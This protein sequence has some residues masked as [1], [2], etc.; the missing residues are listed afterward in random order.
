MKY[1]S[2]YLILFIFPFV[3]FAQEPVKKCLSGDDFASWNEIKNTAISPDGKIVAFEQNP[4]KG[5]GSLI[6]HFLDSERYDT[7]PR[8]TKPKFGPEN[9]FLVFTIAQPEKTIRKAKL[10]KVK[11]EDMPGDSLGVLIFKN[12]S[13]QK[14]PDLKSVTL[15]EKNSHWF[16]F[17]QKPSAPTDSASVKTDKKPEKQPGD[18]LVLF[19]ASNSDTLLFRQVTEVFTGKEG[20]N[21]IFVSQN[22]DSLST[23]SSVFLFDTATEQAKLIFENEG[24]AKKAVTDNGGQKFAFLFSTDTIEEKI[25]SLYYGNQ[26][27]LPSEIAGTLTEGM[28]IGWSPGENGRIYFSDDAQKL[29]FGT[30][31]SPEPEPKDTLPDDE[32]PKL[33]VWNW[34]DNLLQTQQKVELK[35]E[36]KRTYLAVLH[37]D[38]QKFIQLGFPDIKNISTIQKGNAALAL[39]IDDTP[40]QRSDSWE[41][42]GK[43]DFYLVDL[44]TGIKRQVVK[45]KSIVSLSPAGKYVI[46]YAPSDSGYY[47][48]STEISSTDLKPL[49][50]KIPVTFYDERDDTP[51]DPRPYGIAGW[52]ADDRSVFIYDRYDI[53][54][55][56]P[57]DDRVPVC[58]TKAF[59]RRNQTRLRIIKLDPE[60]EFLSMEKPVL[61]EAFDERT[62][63]AGFFKTMLN[64]VKDPE[65]LIADKSLFSKPVKAKNADQV[66]WTKEDIQTFPDLWVSN[67]DF[68]RPKRVSFANPQQKDFIWPTAELAEWNSFS[69]EK[70]KG[71]LIKPENLNPAKKYPMI[72]YYYER[73]SESLYRYYPPSPSRSTVEKSFYASNGYLVFIP[74][75]TYRVGYPGESAYNAVV[76]GANYLIGKYPF[77]DEKRIGL[78]GQSWGGYQTAYLITRTDMFAA[79]MAGAPV[80]NMTSAYGGIRWQAGVSRMFQYEHFQSRIGGTLWEKPLFYI[81]NSP[82]FY[83]PKIK[84][85]LLMMHNDDDGAVPWTQGIELFVALRRLDKPAWL[86]DY[87]G[88]PHNLNAESWANRIDLSK[89]MFQ[90]FNHYLKGQ[91]MPEWMQ[92]GIPAVKKGKTLGY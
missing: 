59:G 82:L 19:N 26:L 35:D 40:Y 14:F 71:V 81:E 84:T 91:P 43:K 65:L 44:N 47:V 50:K 16:A 46:W 17:L 62:M 11:K 6:V 27:A 33:D 75:I 78:Q 67:T 39:G 15:P 72:I 69:G 45:G 32:K 22:K 12:N 58:I 60:E 88:E 76:S 63:S 13:A 4:Q 52:S 89:R 55:I 51:S 9:D 77:V 3:N 42:D 34:K 79:A 61:L 2:L 37:L 53:W 54:K 25:Y 1:R 28:P 36:Q 30:A 5:D 21:F 74:D 10:D 18:N 24:F 38:G 56:D 73:N 57:T 31:P 41:G 20:A 23:R 68:R 87:N 49:T 8:G 83:A 64:S 86:L 92:K 85:P 66:F 80:S 29:Y 7:I 48:R 70:L 90:F